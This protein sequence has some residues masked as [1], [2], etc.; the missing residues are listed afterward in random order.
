MQWNGTT[1]VLTPSLTTIPESA[2]STYIGAITTNAT[3]ITGNTLQ[4]VTRLDTYRLY[5]SA[6]I[7]G[8]AIRAYQ[9]QPAIQAYVYDTT[10]EVNTFKS[11]HVPPAPSAVFTS[12]DRTSAATAYFPGG[13]GATGD[14][15]A[16]TFQT[17]P[18]RVV[19]PNN[20]S[21]LVSFISPE[22]YDN[23]EFETTLYSPNADDD[24]IGVVAAFARVNSTTNL[25]LMVWRS[26]GGWA[27]NQGLG[28]AQ[29]WNFG[30]TVDGATVP[31]ADKPKLQSN[32]T[33]ANR[34]NAATPAGPGW[35][36]IYTRV[37][38]VRRGNV[39]TAYSSDWST[40]INNVPFLESSVITLDLSTIPVLA[41]LMGSA[42]YGY[43]TISQAGATYYNTTFSG[44][45]DTGRVV[46]LQ[47]N[48]VWKYNFS[49]STW[50]A[51][52][53]TPKDE[54]GYVRTVANP[55]TGKTYF[56]TQDAVIKQ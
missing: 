17:G 42:K 13:V 9:Q 53:T 23:Y 7:I 50:T 8:S 27:Q 11:T 4:K 20:T 39:I 21:A 38:V 45:L 44:G 34:A 18:D 41:P 55:D 54:L 14:A 2:T 40:D 30:F 37:R 22:S 46:D 49:T 16:W 52:A 48:T 26:G 10:A 24:V 35:A 25:Q 12:W 33:G 29:S 31:A 6:P 1:F 15:A 32:M 5:N 28:V 51:T 56:V 3:G 19:Q 36:G 43:T 47:T